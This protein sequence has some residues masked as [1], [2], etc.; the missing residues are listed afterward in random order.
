M[1]DDIACMLINI[2]AFYQKMWQCQIVFARKLRYYI[3]QRAIVVIADLDM[4]KEVMV[5]QF[6][7]FRDR[8]HVPDFLR[9][10]SGTARGIFNAR[11]DYWKKLRVVLSPTFSTGKMKMV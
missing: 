11:G 3:G 9:R 8:P 5:K 4:L 6:D 2:E 7:I 10:K 1:D